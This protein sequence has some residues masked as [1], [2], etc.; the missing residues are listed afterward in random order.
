MVKRCLELCK[1]PLEEFSVEDLGLMIGQNFS[2]R[3]LIPLAI[4]HLQVDIFVEGNYYPGG[5]LKNV[6]LVDTG[7]WL[8][9]AE[10]WAQVNGL[11][12]DKRSELEMQKIPTSSFDIAFR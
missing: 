7:F 3:Y 2:L 4:E 1:I 5:L 9:N 10:L 12:E 6:L 8:D 11:I